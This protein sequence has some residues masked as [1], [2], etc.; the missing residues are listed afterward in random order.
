[1]YVAKYWVFQENSLK[2][3]QDIDFEYIHLHLH[4]EQPKNQFIFQYIFN[5]RKLHIMK[6]I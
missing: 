3:K 2:H 6:A 1:M 4:S 5:I